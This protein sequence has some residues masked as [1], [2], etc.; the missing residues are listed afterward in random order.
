MTLRSDILRTALVALATGA[1][2]SAGD[3]AIAQVQ[4]PA[5]APSPAVPPAPRAPVPPTVKQ[6]PAV[7]APAEPVPSAEAP[8]AQPRG[9]VVARGAGIEIT[10]DDVRALMAGL[11]AQEQ[12]A[13][14]RDPSLLSQIVRANM[15]NQ[16][17][18]KEA[19]VKKWDQRADV[20]AQL[21]RIRDNALA[22]IYLR[23]VSAPPAGFPTDAEV[24]SVYEANKTAF[25]VPRQFQVAQIFIALTKDA[26]KAAEEKALRKLDDVR[27][28]SKQPGADFAALAKAESE[29]RES[30]ERGG[31]I[32]LLTEAQLRPEIRAQI[33]GL[34]KGAVTE[35]VRLDD[36]WHILKLLDTKAAYT[37]PI[38]E[39][40]EALG[41]RLRAER[42]E[43]NRHAYTAELLKQ[44]PPAINELSLSKLVLPPER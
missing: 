39:V 31:E 43:A 18:L 10:L 33:T 38:E 9:E 27:G 16:L 36:G 30:A 34:A 5:K 3:L 13:V 37:R 1:M 22:E 11:G 19:Q 12:A 44:N 4:P 2:L 24:Q 20:A 28:R 41:Q 42:A 26:D 23:S 15:A 6:Q 25:A 17:V 40:R 29:E 8:R 7:R 35:P 32:G 14:V 21:A